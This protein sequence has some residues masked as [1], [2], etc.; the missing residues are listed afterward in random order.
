MSVRPIK[1]IITTLDNLPLLKEQI[2]VLRDDPYIDEIVVVNNGSL[3]GTKDWLEN[4][5]DLVVVNRKNDGAGPGRN[6]GIDAADECDYYLMLDGGIRPLRGG[7]EKL[8]AYLDETPEC[9]VIGVEIPDFETDYDKAW[10]RWPGPITPDTTYQNTRLSHTAYC[11]ARHRAFD[12]LRFCEEGPFGEPGWGVDDD[13]MAYQW[14]EAGIVVHV[15]VGI[16]P[17]RRGSGSFRRLWKETGIWPNQHGSVY[18]KRLV[19]C[20]Q[21]WAKYQPGVQWGEP[22]PERIITIV[23]DG[24]DETAKEI[25]AAHELMRK[26]RF[27]KPW[28]YLWEPY[29]IVVQCNAGNVAFLEWA[30]PRRLRQHHGDRTVVNGEIVKRGPQNEETWTGDFIL[31]VVNAGTGVNSD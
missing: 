5:E 4:E 29:R 1:A 27:D 13:E 19:W 6:S 3:D 21:R 20:Q 15:V 31:E 2:P 10:R 23:A 12:G 11:L 16:H 17:Y 30:E 8:L 22:A 9:D 26:D 18:E 25:K 24:V 7:T 28:D 14:N